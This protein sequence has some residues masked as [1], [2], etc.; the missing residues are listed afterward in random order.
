MKIK[1]EGMFDVIDDD[2]EGVSLNRAEIVDLL[3]DI[4]NRLRESYKW[5]GWVS[6]FKVV[7]LGNIELEEV[8]G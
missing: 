1:F 2:M 5:R 6:N 7:E 3:A 4:R 8:D